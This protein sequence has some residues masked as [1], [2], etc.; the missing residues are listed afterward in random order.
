MYEITNVGC[1]N[2]NSLSSLL[3]IDATS[4]NNNEDDEVLDPNLTHEGWTDFVGKLVL[5]LEL[6]PP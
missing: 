4:S 1:P 3:Q 6:M 2:S 5:P